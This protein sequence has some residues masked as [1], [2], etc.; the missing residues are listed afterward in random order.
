MDTRAICC[1]VG[2]QDVPSVEEWLSRLPSGSAVGFDP[3]LTSEGAILSDTVF[4]DLYCSLFVLQLV[5]SSTASFWSTLAKLCCPFQSTLWMWCGPIVAPPGQTSLSLF[6][7]CSMQ[8]VMC[9]CVSLCLSLSLS[10]GQ[11]WQDKLQR[12]REKL[13][14][15]GAEALVITALDEVACMSLQPGT[16]STVPLVLYRA[17]QLAWF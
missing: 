13:S 17:F 6:C 12:V 11:S 5:S 16:C 4:I 10:P 3:Q 7:P 15:E 2:N 1:S 14:E 9:V 8:V